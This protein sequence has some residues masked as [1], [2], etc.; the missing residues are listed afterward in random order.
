MLYFEVLFLDG[1]R[2]IKTFPSLRK[3]VPKISYSVTKNE[4]FYKASLITKKGS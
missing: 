2:P 4:F 3:K 1:G